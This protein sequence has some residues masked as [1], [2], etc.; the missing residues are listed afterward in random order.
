MLSPTYHLRGDYHTRA[1]EHVKSLPRSR[2]LRPAG[3]LPYTL[4]RNLLWLLALRP[5]CGAPRFDRNLTA[6]GCLSLSL[7]VPLRELEPDESADLSLPVPH[8]PPLSVKEND[9]EQRRSQVR[10]L[11]S[12]PQKCLQIVVNQEGPGSPPGLLTLV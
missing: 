8:C 3:G 4:L 7:P 1:Y 2:R 12:A 10:V 6:I 5:V 9:Y 11:P